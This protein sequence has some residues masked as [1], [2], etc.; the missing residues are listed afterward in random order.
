MA[1]DIREVHLTDYLPNYLK[2][3]TEI[4]QTLIAE[5]PEFKLLWEACNGL[6]QNAFTAT[7]DEYGIERREKLIG[8]LPSEKDTL[9][10]RRSRVQALWWNQTPYSIRAFVKKLA[11]LCGENN[12]EVDKT[13]LEE[14]YLGIVTHLSQY[15]QLESLNRI[16]T[17]MT[18]QNVIIDVLNE[19]VTITVSA[20]VYAGTVTTVGNRQQIDNDLHEDAEIYINPKVL[21]AAVGEVYEDCEGTFGVSKDRPVTVQPLSC[22][23]HIGSGVMSVLSEGGNR[24]VG[25][26]TGTITNASVVAYSLFSTLQ[27]TE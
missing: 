5:D 20:V 23:T 3:Y 15:G 17:G 7:A 16:V 2:G 24:D 10:S 27:L 25:L 11:E 9:E 4:A 22:G 13:R 19:I 26:S 18:P 12:F 1:D 6:L 8:V 21:I 14:Y